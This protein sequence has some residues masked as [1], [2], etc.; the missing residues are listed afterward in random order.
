MIS[1]PLV[2]KSNF[3]SVLTPGRLHGLERRVRWLHVA[4]ERRLGPENLAHVH[5]PPSKNRQLYR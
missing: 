2:H 5:R 4:N 3:C 1:T